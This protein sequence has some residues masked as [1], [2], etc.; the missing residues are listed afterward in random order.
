M[1]NLIQDYIKQIQSK[2]DTWGATEHTYRIV[3]ETLLLGIANHITVTN[4]HE[5]IVWVWM[6]DFTIKFKQDNTIPIWRIE[7]KDLHISLEE[8]KNA[9]QLKRYKDAFDNFIYTNYL[10]FIFYRNGK[11]IDVVHLWELWKNWIE[12]KTDNLFDDN[13]K[14]L[15]NLLKEFLS[16]QGITI[17]SPEKLAKAMAQ[18]AQLIKYAIQSIFEQEENSNLELEYQ[19]FKSLLVH[20]LTKPQFADMY[21]QTVAYGLFSARLYDPNLQTFSRE[22]AEKLI[23]KS[24][25]FIR[26]LF[27]Q[28]SNDDEFDQRIAYIIDDLVNIFLHCNVAEILKN[29][30]KKTKMEDP[31]IHFCEKFLGEYD[32]NMRKKSWV[33]YTS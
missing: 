28:M 9:D 22:E 16:F 19:A 24:T 20:D 26:W 17:T 7:A 6:P 5:R 1:S 25:P 31:I 21:A 2:F 29:Y 15:N 12:R 11:K 33:Y 8:S 18:K 27:K 14:K 13:I 23:P 4:E 10:T 30:G 32:S 3:L